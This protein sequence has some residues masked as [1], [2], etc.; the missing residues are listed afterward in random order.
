MISLH[1]YSNQ[2]KSFLNVWTM[3][4]LQCVSLSINP[5][6]QICGSAALSVQSE[7]LIELCWCV[8]V[9]NMTLCNTAHLLLLH[10]PF[11]RGGTR[12]LVTLQHL[13]LVV[14]M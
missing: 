10:A 6:N 13:Q 7:L 4:G 3:L 14:I 5:C 1:N 2:I 12:E 9:N 11:N 8:I